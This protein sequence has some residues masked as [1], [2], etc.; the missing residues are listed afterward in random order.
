MPYTVDLAYHD[1]IWN[2]I[3][4]DLREQ[5][6]LGEDDIVTEMDVHVEV[7]EKTT[8]TNVETETLD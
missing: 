1:E 2:Q 6:H 7:G 3:L 8:V 5:G 4:D